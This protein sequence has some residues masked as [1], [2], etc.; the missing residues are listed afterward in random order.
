[1]ID[2]QHFQH[3]A[4]NSLVIDLKG[5]LTTEQYKVAFPQ[6]ESELASHK[7]LRLLFDLRNLDGWGLNVH[8]KNLN[9]DSRHNTDVQ[10]MAILGSRKWRLWLRR[11]CRP[12]NCQQ[13]KQFSSCEENEA[14]AW[15]RS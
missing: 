3:D 5:E 15:V 4:D 12:L 11:A 10:K 9:F 8:W 6:L 14:F 13:F 1:M 7:R 2:I